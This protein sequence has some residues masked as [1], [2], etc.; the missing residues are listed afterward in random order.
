MGVE[1][2]PE[3][4]LLNSSARLDSTICELG[5]LFKFP[6][7]PVHTG[8]YGAVL[9]LM[10]CAH[11]GTQI[12]SRS[13]FCSNCGA[14]LELG[15][16]PSECANDLL[17]SQVGGT[18]TE[19]SASSARPWVRYWARAVDL[20]LASLAG[21]VAAGIVFPSALSWEGSALLFG[22]SIVFA[23]VFVEALLLSTVG[24]T[25]G[26]WL[27]RTRVVTNSGAKPDYF[28][29]LSRS[30]RVWWRGLAGGLPVVSLV[31]IIVAHGHLTKNGLTTW[32]RDG[33]FIVTHERIGPTRIVLAL[34]FLWIIATIRVVGG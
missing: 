33:G 26:K 8:S 34:A 25:P 4:Q 28:L 1:V 14:D 27:F 32:D 16:P 23:W 18:S 31:T 2:P 11:C 29:A 9:A 17:N 13:K 7:F 21:G 12:L 3:S 19:A 15:P 5:K 24:F 30:L 20:Y 22:L 6:G 10:F